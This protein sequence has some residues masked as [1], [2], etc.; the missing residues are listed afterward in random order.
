MRLFRHC[1]G[2]RAV[3]RVLRSVEFIYSGPTHPTGHEQESQSVEVSH[4]FEPLALTNKSFEQGPHPS[5]ATNRHCLEVLVQVSHDFN[6]V[7]SAAMS[8]H[9]RSQDSLH[10]RNFVNQP[11]PPPTQHEEEY[12]SSAIFSSPI[13]KDLKARTLTPRALV[14]NPSNIV[15]HSVRIGIA[16]NKTMPRH[17]LLDLTGTAI[18]P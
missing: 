5:F 15:K 7:C 3:A 17:A 4:D 18:R 12:K 2:P 6:C 13:S 10:S 16:N 14:T 1:V 9:A 11:P 8:A